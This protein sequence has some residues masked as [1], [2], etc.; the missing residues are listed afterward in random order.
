MESSGNCNSASLCKGARTWP[1]PGANDHKGT[2]KLGQRRGQ[3]DE[4]AEQKWATPRASMVDNGNDSGSAQRLAQGANP[5]LKTQVA[6]WN[7][8]GAAMAM[9][10]SVCRGNERSGELLLAGQAERVSKD[11]LRS[12]PDQ[13]TSM[14]GDVPS[15]T[16]PNLL[17][18]LNPAFVFWLMGWPVVTLSDSPA[19]AFA[20]WRRRMRSELS[21]PSFFQSDEV[22]E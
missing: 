13:A 11:Y 19:T 1:T 8:P 2:A 6:Q 15:P 9:A 7:T 21:A 16:V 3:L 10:G 17:P 18:R 5:G 12:R 20:L 14:L 22:R 4:A